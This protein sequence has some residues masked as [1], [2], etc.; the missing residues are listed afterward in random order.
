MVP[1]DGGTILEAEDATSAEWTFDAPEPGTYILEVRYTLDKKGQFP[2]K[3][4]VNAL[5]AFEGIV[6][7]SS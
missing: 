6:N 4:T 3:V 1:T 5:Q 2:S 7:I